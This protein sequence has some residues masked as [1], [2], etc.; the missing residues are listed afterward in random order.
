MPTALVIGARNLGF[1]VI[2]RLLSDGWTVAGAARSPE[3]LAKV[4][5][6]GAEALDVDVT[7]QASVHAALQHLGARHGR[8]D[9]AVNAASPY[10]GSRPFGGGPLA[11]ATPTS[12]DDW[13]TLPARGAFG[14]LSACAR[15][16]SAQGG[17][18]TIVQV[19]GGSARRGMPGR[20]LWAAGA[21]G[22]RA[23][24]QAAA[25]E[26]REQEIHVALLIVDAAIDRSGGN[27]T[28]TADPGSLA[29]AVVYLAAQSPRA[30]T[31]ELQVTPARD[32]WTP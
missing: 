16:M 30:M 6:A 1:A 31:H 3:T 32:N 26:L 25:S 17:P 20:G 13:A 2:E 4:R 21:F 19:T 5:N 24:T 10:G 29:D 9:L 23:L 18:A 11:H 8:V 28:A 14:F 7:D 12:F 22:V 15:F 27:D